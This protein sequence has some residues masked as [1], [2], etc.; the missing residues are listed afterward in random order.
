MES[1]EQREAFENLVDE[2]SKVNKKNSEYRAL[3]V[4]NDHKVNQ[5]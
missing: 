3:I 1:K 4:D 2:V 5:I